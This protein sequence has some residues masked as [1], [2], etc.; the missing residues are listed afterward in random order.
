MFFICGGITLLVMFTILAEFFSR[1]IFPPSGIDIF[2]MNI[3]YIGILFIYSFHKEMLR[4]VGKKHVERKGE[5]FVYLWIGL[6]SELYVLNF[7]TRGYFSSSPEGLPV[8]SLREASTITLEVSLIFLLT[9]AFK[10]VAIFLGEKN[11]NL[12]ERS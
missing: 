12:S 10:I 11:K 9:R 8:E 2:Y 7:L 6:T 5:W 4:W 3:F 1:G